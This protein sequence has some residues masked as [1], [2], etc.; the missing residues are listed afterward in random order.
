M[1]VLLGPSFAGSPQG[2]AKLAELSGLVTYDLRSRIKPGWWGVIRALAD[3]EQANDLVARL[4][5][6]G[7]PVVSVELDCAWNPERRFVKVQALR[8]EP[9]ELVLRVRDQEMVLPYAAVLT[10]V[11]GEL[12]LESRSLPRAKGSSSSAFR[13][14][15][16]G[17]DVGVSRDGAGRSTDSFQATDLH[18]HTARWIARI[19]PR[20]AD[21]ASVPGTVGTHAR[22]LEVVTAEI[23][24]RTGLRV[25]QGFR[26]SS[27]SSY[28]MES[29]RSATPA[30]GSMADP[31]S[32]RF[33]RYSRLVGEA[34]AAAH[35]A[36]R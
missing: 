11:R 7:F 12:G 9:S 30:P 21:L 20:T 24:S 36:S 17:A 35:V 34:E 16:V 29:H 27:L 28:V 25:D 15:V 1:L 2:F 32:D 33:D 26:M 31:H 19:D 8:L 22:D 14:V 18:F 23:A 4:R 10:I 5:R 3:K 13:V 6:E